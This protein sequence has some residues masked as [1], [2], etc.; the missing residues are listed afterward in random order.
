[1]ARVAGRLCGGPLRV[2]DLSDEKLAAALHR[3]IHEQTAVADRQLSRWL[4]PDGRYK[5]LL[6]FYLGKRSDRA[7]AYLALWSA[8]T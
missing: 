7:V 5:R 2:L 1:M 8:P 4:A 6:R 3:R